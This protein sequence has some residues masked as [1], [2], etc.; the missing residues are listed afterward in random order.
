MDRPDDHP[1]IGFLLNDIARLMRVAFERRAAPLGLTRA[2]WSVLA[3]LKRH[4]GVSQATLAQL[5]EVEPVTVTRLIDR[6]DRSG[7][8]ER[9]P[10]PDDRRVHRLFLTPAARPLLDQI[11]RLA[12]EVRAEA[13]EGIA[14]DE[15]ATFV[16]V[17][18]RIRANL[19]EAR[20]SQAS[21]AKAGGR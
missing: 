17:A 7:M 14:A 18:E 5:M 16:A 3:Q 6:L 1:G 12:R 8:V 10:D 13:L 4:P 2:R 11:Q 21:K 20:A 15:L 9:R 19:S